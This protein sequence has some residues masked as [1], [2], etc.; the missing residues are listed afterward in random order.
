MSTHP[1]YLCVVNG[2]FRSKKNTSFL[3]D[4]NSLSF[5]YEHEMFL[6]KRRNLVSLRSY[7]LDDP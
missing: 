2:A 7:L 1:Q 5:V 3:A 6:L 4:L